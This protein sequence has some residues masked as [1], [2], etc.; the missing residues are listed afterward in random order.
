MNRR[1][2]LKTTAALAPCLL[3][4]QQTQGSTTIQPN[5]ASMGVLV[6][7]TV[8]IGCRKCEW[9]CNDVNHLTNQPIETFE[10]KS[11]YLERRFPSASRYTVVNE[12]DGIE[13]EKP[14]WVKTQCM[15]CVDPACVSACL[16]NALE[17]NENGAVIYH[18]DRC[19]GCRYC[20]VA[21]PFQAN[22]YEYDNAF[23]P[24]VRK[25][26]L[27]IDRIKEKNGVPACVEICPPQCLTYG[28][29]EE[30]VALAHEKIERHPDKYVNHVYGETEI[31]GTAWLYIANRD[32]LELGFPK[33][34]TDSP[35]RLTE[36]IQHGVFRH[37]I[38][39]LAL[40]LMLAG[41]MHLSNPENAKQEEVAS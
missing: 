24:Q 22:A 28:H 21:C 16:V 30:L 37:F 26:N 25:C 32:F 29:R 5:P 35:P 40:F 20:M 13:D 19:M 3:L 31:G 15:H 38:P 11:A 41:V 12:M 17:K 18:A 27:C 34:G 7:T 33:L 4:E 8:C 2:L 36:A 23:T 1:N 39:P 6:D 9:A 14:V 10:N